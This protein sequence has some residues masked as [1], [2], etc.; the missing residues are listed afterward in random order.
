[1]QLAVREREFARCDYDGSG[2]LS[3]HE[4]AMYLLSFAPAKSQDEF[5][6]RADALKADGG[7]DKS[8]Q[9]ITKEDFYT[10]CELLQHLDD[11]QVW[12]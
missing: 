12:D 10:F 4:F 1:M 5:A 9:V 2:V 8:A 3:A 6:R 7:G 11:L